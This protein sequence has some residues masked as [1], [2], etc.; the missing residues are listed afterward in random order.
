MR[1]L[2]VALA[3]LF[4]ISLGMAQQKKTTK[5]KSTASKSSIPSAT[6]V[7][8]APAKPQSTTLTRYQSTT[9]A[10]LEFPSTDTTTESMDPVKRQAMYDEL[11]G[12]KNTPVTPETGGENQPAKPPRQR[13][14]HADG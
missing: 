7:K 6:T 3:L 2:F 14:T 4:S 5:K 11:H 8:K 9:T 1:T 12:V 10:P 13:Y